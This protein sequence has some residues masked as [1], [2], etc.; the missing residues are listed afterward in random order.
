MEA[1]YQLSYSPEVTRFDVA[2][3]DGTGERSL[4][5][6]SP[7][8]G[9]LQRRWGRPALSPSDQAWQDFPMDAN[10]VFPSDVDADAERFVDDDEEEVGVADHLGQHDEGSEADIADQQRVVPIDDDE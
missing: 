5:E 10:D 7:S 9:V 3:P 8:V 6:S 1:L 2:E 4:C